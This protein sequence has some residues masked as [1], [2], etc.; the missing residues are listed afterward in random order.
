MLKKDT[1]FVWNAEC[2]QSF[3]QLRE[4]L[5][6]PPVLA[7]PQ[8]KPEVPFILETVASIRGLGAVLAQE[9]DDWKIHP[10]AYVSRSLN[11]LERNYGITELEILGLVWVARLF[12]PYLLGHKRIVY[13]DHSACTSLLNCNH[14]SARWAL[15]V[16]E[17]DLEI[18]HRSGKSNANA[19]AFILLPIILKIKFT[20]ASLGVKVLG[21]IIHYVVYALMLSC[22]YVFV[23]S[24]LAANESKAAGGIS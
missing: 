9:Q 13:T 6:S 23:G 11:T 14:P 22:I 18:K 3:D 1:S 20:K 19:D 5:I 7:H 24:C 10:I 17:L 12:R 16:Q 2:Q 15:I 4:C 21:L 8:F